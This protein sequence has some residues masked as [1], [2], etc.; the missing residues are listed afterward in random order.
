MT[1]EKKIPMP[2]GLDREESKPY[3]PPPLEDGP[4][5]RRAKVEAHQQMVYARGYL[6]AMIAIASSL[7][8][9]GPSLI[10][11]KRGIDGMFSDGMLH[12]I[13]DPT[14]LKR[15]IGEKL[16]EATERLECAELHF[17][18]VM[19]PDQELDGS[20][21]PKPF[22]HYATE[23]ESKRITKEFGEAPPKELV[24]VL[25]EDPRIGLSTRVPTEKL[26]ELLDR[27][28]RAP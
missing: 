11:P 16:A 6:D 8:R 10:A 27:D 18:Q 7:E 23:E 17:F 24:S 5:A 14:V 26:V 9:E 2:I 19:H 25:G 13:R 1:D 22:V 4:E 21:K 12:D 20:P 15:A 3:F 28:P